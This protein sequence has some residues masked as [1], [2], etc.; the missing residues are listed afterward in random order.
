MYICNVGITHGLVSAYVLLGRE[1]II[2]CKSHTPR[3][4]GRECSGHFQRREDVERVGGGGGGSKRRK[5]GGGGGGGCRL[6]RHFSSTGWVWSGREGEQDIRRGCVS[7]ASGWECV[8]C[9]YGV[10]TLLKWCGGEGGEGGGGR[11][12]DSIGGWLLV[13]GWGQSWRWC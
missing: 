13:G 10:R 4:G 5:R 1:R 6:R 11:R 8:H 12:E 3:E 2:C 7:V 9:H